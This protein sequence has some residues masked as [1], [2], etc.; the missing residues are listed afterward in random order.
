MAHT[1]YILVSSDAPCTPTL[2]C[3]LPASSPGSTPQLFFLQLFVLQAI[4]AGNEA[5]TL[6]SQP[7]SHPHTPCMQSH[8]FCSLH[9]VC[10][11]VLDGIKEFLQLSFDGSE[12]LQG[13]GE[14]QSLE[15][16]QRTLISNK[17]LVHGLA[18]WAIII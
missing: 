10:W 8:P 4:K 7:L 11:E 18:V 9:F 17:L 5:S 3:T 1:R 12:H 14:R 6:H 15:Y 2:H 16:H 13:A